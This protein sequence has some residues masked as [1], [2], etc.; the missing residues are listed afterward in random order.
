MP[1]QSNGSGEPNV[2]PLA[3]ASKS[4]RDDADQLDKAGQ[5]KNS[6]RLCRTLSTFRLTLLLASSGSRTATRST[7]A[8]ASTSSTC[9]ASTSSEIGR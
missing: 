2:I 9:L 7:G 6:P 5:T 1:T 8:T 3:P 4:V